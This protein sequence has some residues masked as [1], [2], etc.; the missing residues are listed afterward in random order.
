MQRICYIV[1]AILIVISCGGN[2]A[3]N[4]S[5]QPETQ[6]DSA[7]TRIVDEILK[8]WEKDTTVFL[9]FAG[10]KLGSAPRLKQYEIIKKS[11]ATKEQLAVKRVIG[12]LVFDGKQY[13]VDID[14]STV[15]DTICQIS[16][17][18]RSDIYKILVD[19]YA[20]KYDS[21]THGRIQESYENDTNFYHD[22]RFSNQA[23]HLNRRANYGWNLDA[24][25]MRKEYTFK[26]ITI[27]YEDYELYNRFQSLWAKQE[28]YER[29]MKPVL[30][31]IARVKEKAIQDSL[32]EVERQR[33]LK[34]ADQ[35]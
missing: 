3:N 4:N 1:L 32:R 30:D 11:T 5:Q 26:Y 33:L 25:P 8:T 20:A 6:V 2:Q 21:P 17:K 23:I 28:Y 13:N 10:Y 34:N 31:S 24:R 29:K 16:G 15:N 12:K 14:L 22:W 7:V 35:I 9:S 18:L 19:T 27:E